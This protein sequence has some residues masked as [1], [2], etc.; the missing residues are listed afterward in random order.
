MKICSDHWEKLRVAIDERGLSRLVAQ[1]G[2][3]AMENIK[4][5]LEGGDPP[6]DPLMACN[7]MIW[8]EGLRLGGLYLMSQK[9]D[10]SQYCPICEALLHK[11]DDVSVELFED[12]WIKG[13]ADAVLRHC[14]EQGLIPALQ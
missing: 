8:A 1:S 7:N 3:Q 11:L 6:Y 10:G 4:E 12:Y 14:R 9:E 13:P 5:E 2:E